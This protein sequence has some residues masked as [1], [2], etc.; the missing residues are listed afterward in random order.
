MGYSRQGVDAFI[1]KHGSTSPAAEKLRMIFDSFAE[2]LNNAALA[3]ACQPIVSIFLSKAIYG[4]R[5][6]VSAEI[7]YKD[8][9]LGPR[10]S[11]AEINE[12][13]SML[14]D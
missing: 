14:S 8:D 13:Y 4:Y 5:D 10:K 2:L 6:T 1:N 7:E 9:P 3:S 11:A 12:I